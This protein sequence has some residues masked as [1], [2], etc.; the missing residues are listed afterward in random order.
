MAMRGL[1][2][3]NRDTW[4]YALALFAVQYLIVTLFPDV[5]GYSGWFLF[6]FI[7]GRFV[8]IQHPPSENEAPLSQG[9]VILGWIALIIFIICFAPNPLEIVEI[10]GGEG[11][12]GT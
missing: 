4:M 9:R 7:I 5:R 6:A 11:I 8:G 2:L 3:S 12:Q 1:A 10:I